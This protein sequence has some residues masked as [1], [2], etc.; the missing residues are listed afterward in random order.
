MRK[1][2]TAFAAFWLLMLAVILPLQA[3]WIENGTVICK[4]VGDQHYPCIAPDGK[5]GAII[6]WHDDRTGRFQYNIYAQRTNETGAIQWASSGVVICARPY[7]YDQQVVVDD[8]GGAVIVWRDSYQSANLLYAQKIDADGAVLWEE[9]GVLLSTK[10]GFAPQVITDDTGGAIITWQ[11]NIVGGEFYDIIAQCISAEGNVLWTDDGVTVCSA[12]GRQIYTRIIADGAGGAI[13]VWEDTR[14]CPTCRDIYAQRVNA[15]GIVQ[16]NTEGVAICSAADRQDS[17]RITSDHAG[18]AIITWQDSRNG[19]R[20]S[21]IYAQRIEKNGVIQWKPDGVA[22]C[23]A[24]GETYYALQEHQSIS[25]GEGGAIITWEDSRNENRNVNI[26]AQ[27]IDAGGVAV[28]KEDGVPISVAPGS[29]IHP[30]IISDG[31]GGAIITWWEYCKDTESAFNDDEPDVYA[32]RIDAAGNVRWEKD[33]VTISIGIGRQE[34]PQITSDGSGGAIIVWQDTRNTVYSRDF[35][36][37]CMRVD[38]N[39]EIPSHNIP[40]EKPAVIR[41]LPHIFPNPFNPQ[42]QVVYHVNELCRVTLKVFDC[43]GKLVKTLVNCYQEEGRHEVTWD[44]MDDSGRNVA[45]GVYFC[46]ISIGPESEVR[47]LVLM[48]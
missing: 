13:I 36:V 39:G 24:S 9:N 44:G 35:D 6:V 2:I 38:S 47:K 18:G 27:R 23:L 15:D 12:E 5:G 21:G 8:E 34:Y 28:W 25:D 14:S 4:E 43:S 46:H 30:Q 42:T 32:Q 10:A 16:C 3:D 19:I 45:S 41:E 1:G 31:A 20:H 11:G 40:S 48:K 29:K 7:S 22:V 26:Y 37:Y 33:G 17:P